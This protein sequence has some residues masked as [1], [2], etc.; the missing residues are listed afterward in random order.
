MSQNLENGLVFAR[1]LNSASRLVVGYFP[2][3]FLVALPKNGQ[4]EQP[5]DSL[6]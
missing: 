1:E 3:N 4:L 6:L 2:A 5:C